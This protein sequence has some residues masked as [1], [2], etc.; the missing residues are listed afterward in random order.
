MISPLAARSLAR[1][2]SSTCAS[3][4]SRSRT[5]PIACMSSTSILAARVDMLLRKNWRTASVAPLSAT[6]S[7]SLSMWRI[8]VC[9]EPASSLHQVVEGEH[10]RLDALGGLAVVLFQRGHEARLGLAV[11]IVEDFRHH[12]V[13]VAAAGLRQARH[14]F[15]AQR[16]LDA[17]QHL[18]LHR[19]HLQH[20]VDDVERRGPPAGWRAR[21]RRARAAAWTAPPRRSAGIRSSDSWRAPLPARWRASP[22]CCGRR[23][24]GSRP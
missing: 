15:G 6:P 5:G 23:G 22:T 19:L 24:R 17:L 1:L 2:T 14:E 13:G 18:L 9:A 12:L 4:T 10:Q 16:L 7:L 11:E 21:A 3:S 8:S 20:A